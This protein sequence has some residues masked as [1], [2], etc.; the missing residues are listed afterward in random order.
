MTETRAFIGVA[1]QTPEQM[2]ATGVVAPAGARV[3]LVTD[4]LRAA[5]EGIGEEDL[6]YEAMWE[7][8][9]DCPGRVVVA[10][11]DVPAPAVTLTAGEE[12]PS[13]AAVEVEVTAA[14]LVSW[15]VAVDA[16]ADAELSWYDASET[17]EVARLLRR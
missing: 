11:V 7:A 6:E 12:R 15:H 1:P 17:V 14:R 3:H 4:A 5:L 8:A 10:A 2:G 13:A 16:D 9:A